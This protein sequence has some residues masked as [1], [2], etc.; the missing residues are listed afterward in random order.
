MWVKKRIFMWEN[1]RKRGDL[2]A[3]AMVKKRVFMLEKERKRGV[4]V[5]K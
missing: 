3:E 5:G 2:G 4:F 1:R